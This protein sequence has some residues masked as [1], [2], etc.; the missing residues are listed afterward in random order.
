VGEQVDRAKEHRGA[1]QAVGGPQQVGGQHVVG[2]FGQLM[3]GE[4]GHHTVDGRRRD[5]QEQETTDHLEQP[6]QAFEDD[7]DLEGL[8]EEVSRP[9][10]GHAVPRGRV[11]LSLT[12]GVA[13]GRHGSPNPF[14]SLGLVASGGGRPSDVERDGPR[15]PDRASLVS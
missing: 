2:V 1:G 9:E 4:A 13:P 15:L 12:W 14:P 7:A 8:V 10:P 3:L 6:V 5:H 11:G